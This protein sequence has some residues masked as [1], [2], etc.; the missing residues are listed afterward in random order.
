[1]P[2]AVSHSAVARRFF[3]EHSRTKSRVLALVTRADSPPS[4]EAVLTC[5]DAVVAQQAA[6]L[7]EQ[8]VQHGRT[9]SVKAA[10]EQVSAALP[11]A[12]RA[13]LREALEYAFAGTWPSA[14]KPVVTW[15]QL[16]PPEAP[17]ARLTQDNQ[18][19]TAEDA[20]LA[21]L[22]GPVVRL[23]RLQEFHVHDVGKLLSTA[24]AAGWE[25]VPEHER[26]DE[27]PQDVVGAVMDLAYNSQAVPGVDEVTGA[28]EA[29]MLCSDD[30][31][32]VADWS[33]KPVR[34]DFGTGWRLTSSSPTRP[35]FAALF[36]LPACG[37]GEQACEVCDGWQF[38][39]RTADLVHSALTALADET[40]DDIEEHGDTAVTLDNESEWSVLSR[41]PRLT[42]REDHSWR[43][44]M[45]EAFESL[46]SD[47]ESGEWPEP[48]C[49]AEELALHLAVED[50]PGYR[51]ILDGEQG[52]AHNQ[53]PRH[54]DDY[55]WDACSDTFFQ[56]R[57][58][59]LLFDQA[60]DGIEDP[61]VQQNQLLGIGDM[62]PAVWF[63]PF[64]DATP[65]TS[66]HR[67]QQ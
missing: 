26:G 40:R 8:A 31:D 17:D 49:Y 25:P 61:D 53:L 5:G 24:A 58:V 11:A 65:R 34:V 55:D 23:V 47:L 60:L 14:E 50:A 29:Q 42:W 45:L 9:A 33:A 32:E 57:D 6:E 62:R 44:R 1:M 10:A 41:L 4:L 7:L 2:E 28:A 39:P 15:S 13:S 30:G 64:N 54:D 67:Y 18:P 66:D 52:T 21:D 59:L 22:P 56:D 38:T 3:C 16:H 20:G 12:P 27:D 37:C 19:R 43:R 51:E 46:V 36:P 35:D 48:R 63:E